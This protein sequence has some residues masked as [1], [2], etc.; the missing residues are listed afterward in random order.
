MG[1]ADRPSDQF[2]RRIAGLMVANG[3]ALVLILQIAQ[4]ARD[5]VAGDV[6]DV[7]LAFFPVVWMDF[8]LVVLLCL[9]WGL[10]FGAGKK[11]K[12][13]EGRPTRW[14]WLRPW[15]LPDFRALRRTLH[16]RAI[17]SWTLTVGVA[18]AL[19]LAV[20]QGVVVVDLSGGGLP[21]G[22][23]FPFVDASGG[24]I[25]WAPKLVLAPNPFLGVILRPYTVAVTT[26]LSVLGGLGIGL[27]TFRWRIAGSRQRRLSRATGAVAGALVM[28]PACAASPTFAIF[29]SLLAPAAGGA[30]GAASS[31]GA[32]VDFS[33]VMLMASTIAL[34]IGL[35]RTSQTLR[36]PPEPLSSPE[37]GNRA[38]QFGGW[39]LVMAVVLA[40][41]ALLTDLSSVTPSSGQGHGGE[42]GFQVAT[43]HPP[44]AIAFA[45]LGIGAAA[46]CALMRASRLLPP[47]R[48]A[49]LIIALS[50]LYADGIIHWFAVSEHAGSA[51]NVAFFL[52][53]G[54][55]QV[56][57]VPFVARRKK[58][59]W[60][61]GV[62]FTVFLIALYAVT[63]V[64][65]T[66]LE[67]RP[68]SIQTLG[69]LS[70]AVGA[71][72]L[73]ALAVYFGREIVPNRLRM[74]RRGTTASVHPRAARPRRL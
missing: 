12:A 50:L 46:W 22:T 52:V 16:S 5:V 7:W 70:K 26:L 44:G 69:L 51:P 61:V 54:V 64:V 73:I 31:T 67:P 36:P 66:P 71:G 21:A 14:A 24:P 40:I 39:L 2:P 58:A 65:P 55:V 63:R 42:G 68:E 37:G 28:C 30:T 4:I 20:L 35:A 43:T 33:T 59:L 9:F 56:F 3:L 48:R 38:A 23:L 74:I 47:L 18:Y 1:V 60:W 49:A 8:S 72:L 62:A 27:V 57:A 13:R 32:L 29:A 17:R 11:M 19:L 34:W 41:A 10:S 53:T 15:L 6:D 25:G 45:L